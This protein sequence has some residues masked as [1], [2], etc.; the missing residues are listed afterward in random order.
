[1]QG[2]FS[3]LGGGDM[4]FNADI[5]ACS[6]LMEIFR[7]SQMRAQFS[8]CLAVAIADMLEN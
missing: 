2:P 8:F 5:P 3:V 6:P 7:D 1:M 4:L